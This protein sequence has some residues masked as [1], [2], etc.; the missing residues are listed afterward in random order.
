MKILTPRF[1]RKF[2]L[3]HFKILW[4]FY[5]QRLF[6]RIYNL[7]AMKF[8]SVDCHRLISAQFS[9]EESLWRW[10][11]KFKNFMTSDLH[12]YCPVGWPWRLS[13]FLQLIKFCVILVCRWAAIPSTKWRRL[14]WHEAGEYL[15]CRNDRWADFQYAN[16]WGWNK[17]VIMD[18]AR[19]A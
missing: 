18:G 13:D 14:K 1:H 15:H 8:F 4:N 6:H 19:G 5:S 9:S 11:K 7:A 16:E 10:E 2:S 3:G 17:L 12:N